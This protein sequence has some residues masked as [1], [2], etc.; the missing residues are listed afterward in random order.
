MT[1]IW[2]PY[3]YYEYERAFTGWVSALVVVR[4]WLV[5]LLFVVL[6]RALVSARDAEQV[7][8]LR[9]PVV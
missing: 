1:Q 8:S 9:A 4:D 6:V 3:H 7:D 5:V 2:E